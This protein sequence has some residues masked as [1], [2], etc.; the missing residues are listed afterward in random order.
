MT[1]SNLSILPYFLIS[2]LFLG[3][4]KLIIK[5]NGFYQN[6]ATINTKNLS[7]EGLRGFLALG[8]FF[9]HS[10]IHFQ[11]IETGEWSTPNSS[12]YTM[13]G[14]IAV[15]FFFAITGFLFW[16]KV[17][18]SNTPLDW[19]RL[20]RNRFNRIFPMYL[21]TVFLIIFAIFYKANLLKIDLFETPKLATLTVLQ[22]SKY[23]VFTQPNLPIK[24]ISTINAGVFWTLIWEW[25]FYLALPLLAKLYEVKKP[26]LYLAL[27]LLC[28]TSDRRIPCYFVVGIACAE[29]QQ[30]QIQFTQLQK[31]ILDVVSLVSL[32]ILILMYDNAYGFRQ[33]AISFVAFYCI[34]NGGGL[35][36]LLHLKSAH[37]LGEIS[38][39]IYLLH[40]IL[41]TLMIYCLPSHRMH[42]EYYWLVTMITGMLVIL[43]SSI[44][45]QFIEH[46]F[47]KTRAM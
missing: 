27:I 13:L 7:I 30:K 26:L 19:K 40:G 24:D 28:F 38:Y 11:Y 9:H 21:F 3:F 42:E 33:A 45:H 39:S 36:G 46:P 8:V 44:S 15:A 16:T 18:Q 20:L 41:I 2:I 14:Q 23:I 1:I 37:F 29:L 25:K 32:G 22:L 17:I 34:L 35:L 5:S 10:I 6:A 31:S 47:Y 12:F 43:S 4:A